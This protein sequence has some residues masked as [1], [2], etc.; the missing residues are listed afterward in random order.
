MTELEA[1]KLMTMLMAAFPAAQ[2]P[3][4]TAQTYE[5][6]L[7]ELDLERAVPAV[8]QAIRSSEFMPTIA[9]IVST[10][11]SLAPSKPNGGYRLFRPRQVDNAMPP[12]ELKDAIASALKAMK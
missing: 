8:R 1:S 4:G 11:E 3:D 6:F 7:V 9:K 5:S 12:G 10:Y 2:V